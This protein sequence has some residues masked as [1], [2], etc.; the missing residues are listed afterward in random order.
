M[1]RQTLSLL[2][3]LL[4]VPA[5]LSA[6][7]SKSKFKD[8]ETGEFDMS[9]WLE[10]RTGFLPVP[11]IITEPAV[12]YG[13]GLFVSFF[14]PIEDSLKWERAP[15]NATDV[16]KEYIPPSVSGGGGFVTENG[17]WGGGVYH[18]GFWRRDTF[19]YTGG[20]FRTK[21]NLTFYGFGDSAYQLDHGLDYTLDGW[22]LLQKLMKRIKK[23]NF[24]AG[25]KYVFSD[26]S[27]GFDGEVEISGVTDQEFTATTSII[28]AVAEYDGRDNTFTPNHGIKAKFEIDFSR[29]FIG[30]DFDYTKYHLYGFGF[31]PVSSSVVVGLKLDWQTVTGD[32]PFWS[33]PFI[34]LRGIPAM[35]YQGEYVWVWDAEVRWN[36]HGRWSVDGFFGGGRAMMS[37]DEFTGTDPKF[38]GGVGF[39]YLIARLY[40]LQAGID[41][42]RGPE[43]WAF[44]I[45]AGTWWR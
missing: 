29:E 20:L 39:R 14:H 32:V 26:I 24:F 42:A 2:I 23:S 35:R 16:A 5:M 4:L 12:G 22:F 38:A 33:L 30:S 41:V 11:V 18:Q 36:L 6:E 25:A 40:G 17:T 13:A 10:G 8:P 37:L 1:P 7:S 27:G 31:K 45:V 28:G 21:V 44:Y 19:R 15:E 43:D 9:V 3:V 34:S